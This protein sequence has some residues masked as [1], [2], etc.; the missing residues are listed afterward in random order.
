MTGPATPAPTPTAD[1][2]LRDLRDRTAASSN[3]GTVSAIATT[4]HVVSGGIVAAGAASAGM[5]GGMAAVKCFAGRIA[6]PIAGAMAG[7]ALAEAVH[8]DEAAFWVAKQFGAKRI[9][10]PGP[11]PAHIEHQI[12]HDNTFNGLLAGIAAGIVVGAVVAVSAAA[13]IGTAGMAAP[14]VGAAVAFGAGA[15]GGF[16]TTAIAGAGAKTATLSGP[17]NTGSPNVFLEGKKA[18]RVT[19]TAAC[20]KHPGTPPSAI[21]EGSET[22]YINSLPMARIGHKLSC[23]AVVQE[24]CTTIFADNTTGSYGTPDAALSVAEQLLLSVAEVAGMRSATR[25]GGLLDG[26]LRRLFGEPVDVVT[27]DYA[28]ARTD[29]E[30]PGLLPLRLDRTYPG[31]MRVEGALGP[32]WICNWSQRLLLDAAAGTVLLEDAG[33][34]RLLFAIGDDAHVDARHLKAP[35]Y[36]LTG[37]RDALRLYDSRSQQF[38]LFAPARDPAMPLLAGIE[39]RSG[40]R[41][42]FA[43]DAEGRLRQV[44]VPDG[45]TFRID[46]T[47]QGWITALWMEGEREPVVR[48]RYDAGG[49]LLDVLGSFTGEFHYRYSREGWLNGWQDS[50]LTRVE[51]LYDAAGRVTGTRTGDGMFDDRFLYFPEQRLSRYVDATGA[52]TSFRYDA[53]NLVVEEVDPL[54]ARTISEWDTLERLQRRIDPAG[55]ETRFAYD[56]DGRLIAQTDWA[57]RSA[58][59]RYDRWGALVAFAGPEGS[60]EWT[61]DAAG[62]ITAWTGTDG[63]RGTARYDERGA[64]VEESVV[65]A[66][67]TRYENDAAG[68]PVARHDPPSATGVARVTRYRWDRFGR[69]LDHSDPAGRTSSWFYDR[70]PDNPRG[71]V[72]RTRTPDGGEI[73]FAYDGEGLLAARIRGDGQTTR[74]VHGAFDTLRQTIDPMGATTRFGYDGTGRL[75][76]ITDATG[77]A[78][79]FRYDTAGR[80]EAQL[81]WAGRETRYTRD[82]IG[83]VLAKRMPDA[84][85]QHFEW[86]DRDRIVRVIAGSD[87][88]TYRY[89]DA[90]RL[91]GAT[92]WQLAED[93]PR[94][95]ADVTLSYDGKGR[96]IA[97]EQ[98]GIAV[99]YRYDDAGRC[100]G[101]TSPSGETAMQFDDVG[102]LR[103]YDSNGHTLRFAHD[104]SGLETLR[105]TAALGTRTAFQLAQSYDPAG[106]LAEQRAG[107]VAV[108][109]GTRET[110]DALLR[111]YDW[112]RTGR[113]TGIADGGSVAGTGETRFHYDLRDQAVGVEHGGM[114]E[115]YRYDALMNLAE[116]LAGEHRYW[117]DCVVEAGANRFRYDAR[118]RMVERI[119]SEH[120][121]R[122]RCWRYRWDG[123]DRLVGLETPDGARWRYSYDAFGRRVGKALVGG[124][125][126][127]TR[128]V[129]YVWQGISLAEAWHHAGGED[130]QDRLSIERWHFE[131]GGLRPLAKELVPAGADAQP[132]AAEGEW[133]P[134]V[135]DQLGA[136]HAL[137]GEDGAC[138]WRAEPELW[139]RTRTARALLRERREGSDADEAT[140]CALRFPG[141]WED[142]E[143]G[144]H[145]NLNRY[146]DPDTGQYLSP[147][148]IGVDGGLRTHAYVHDP[149]RWMDPEG[150]AECNWGAWYARQTN[151]RPPTGM[152]RPHA[153]HI[154]FKGDFDNIPP[155]QTALGRSRAVMAKYNIDPVN[156]PDAL[157]WAPNRGHS[158][159]NARQVADGLEAADTRISS[160]NLSPAD[161]TSAMKGELQKIGSS[162]FGWP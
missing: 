133:L 62:N 70:S 45:T 75:T 153:H 82:A 67:T 147:D 144:L 114:R 11:Q 96:L 73:R 33:G 108:F 34:Q 74:F 55:R 146:Y 79:R 60:A 122:P 115:A 14:L 68:R 29:F 85:E 142:A 106:R 20:T 58:A 2:K 128:R 38:L 140:P 139:G 131:P 81:D 91:T 18:A 159:T 120:G 102:L 95:I 46:T 143:S 100:I 6:A 97:E 130:G 76:T 160:Q 136:P 83:R 80:L 13:I 121:F 109:S 129:D 8:A 43:R 36:H 138:R 150:L 4:G 15:A 93:T 35:Y 42:A 65:G 78:W 63:I 117:H 148:P 137:F 25:K 17:I 104:P 23:D 32:R 53:N 40:N 9:A 134:I 19:D 135:A 127:G 118:G 10:S 158:V 64:L 84:T 56:G 145:Y 126:P 26:P 92:T 98:N 47:P 89:D 87:A 77:Q 31:R 39:D 27:G 16:V 161:A 105:E 152:P 149:L 7:A 94:R 141:Q 57:G 155:M 99:T 5:S 28:D 123:F 48:Y 51:I 162:V 69:L 1:A 59:W 157:M 154:V 119:L 132:L 22:I 113:L 107:G 66:G 49:Q 125:A 50:G 24:G 112:D 90:D 3:A 37:T 30:Y 111:R 101:R 54:G 151:T 72:S 41:I 61:R 124:D 86:D 71:A 12:A 52:V 156:D 103:R 44:R 88:I 116:G 21:I 110:P